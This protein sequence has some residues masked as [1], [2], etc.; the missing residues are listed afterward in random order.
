MGGPDEKAG[1]QSWDL[2]CGEASVQGSLESGSTL[3][4]LCSIASLVRKSF[5]L[6]VSQLGWV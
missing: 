3:A 4:E 2:E 6:E 5:S 1:D